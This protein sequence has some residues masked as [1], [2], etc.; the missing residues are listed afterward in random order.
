M[1]LGAT[2]LP[3]ARLETVAGRALSAVLR[4]QSAGTAMKSAKV[5]RWLAGSWSLEGDRRA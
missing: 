3:P 5:L 4:G 1:P 2:I